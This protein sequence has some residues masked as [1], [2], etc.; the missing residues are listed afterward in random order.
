MSELLPQEIQIWYVLPVLRKE[1]ARILVAEHHLSQKETAKL[2][3]ITPSA[4]SQ[5]VHEK[6]ATDLKLTKP[7]KEEIKRSAELLVKNGS[8]MI[9]ELL[10]LLNHKLIQD[11]VCEY[12]KNQNPHLKKDCNICFSHNSSSVLKN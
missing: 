11:L 12:H 10:R 5:Y 7:I 4:V 6:R 2:L 8:S 9:E 1:L 3:G